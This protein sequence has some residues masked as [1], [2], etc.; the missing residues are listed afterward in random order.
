MTRNLNFLILIVANSFLLC[1]ANSLLAED[2]AEAALNAAGEGEFKMVV[3]FR[4]ET[5]HYTNPAKMTAALRTVHSKTRRLKDGEDNQFT[6]TFNVNGSWHQFEHPLGA[7]TVL[8]AVSKVKAMT[9][10]SRIKFGEL[11]SFEAMPDPEDFEKSIQLT[12]AEAQARLKQKVL[13]AVAKGQF[14]QGRPN[15]SRNARPNPQELF[16]QQQ[17]YQQEFAKQLEQAKK[18]GW[19]PDPSKNGGKPLDPK[20]EQIKRMQ[21]ILIH[22]LSKGLLV[23]A[24]PDPEGES[25]DKPK[26][27]EKK[28]EEKAG[29]KGEEKEGEKAEEKVE[30]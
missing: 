13:Q 1:S 15:I 11:G 2:K 4:G 20:A 18:D 6:A 26:N 5:K 29:E 12:P 7:Q 16:K 21:L 3:N 8:G 23:E 10:R 22:P 14:N 9:K 17:R 30:V 24:I 27:A 25:K 19:W 28:A